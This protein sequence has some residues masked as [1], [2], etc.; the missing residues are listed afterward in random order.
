MSKFKFQFTLF[1]SDWV[2]EQPCTRRRGCGGREW[3]RQWKLE[4]QSR[5]SASW[6]DLLS[7]WYFTCPASVWKEVEVDRETDLNQHRRDV[8]AA[9][10]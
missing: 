3:G 8:V 7:R 9:E 6:L 4:P 5:T 10:L 1:L 2:H